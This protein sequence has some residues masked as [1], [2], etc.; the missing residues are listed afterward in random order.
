MCKLRAR[1]RT[2]AHTD[3]RHSTADLPSVSDLTFS[4]SDISLHCTFWM[5]SSCVCTNMCVCGAR[6]RAR[7]THARAHYA[8]A[9]IMRT[10]CVQWLCDGMWLCAVCVC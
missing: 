10:L 4:S 5:L 3:I 8:R 2:P 6:V 1:A 7:I 9:R